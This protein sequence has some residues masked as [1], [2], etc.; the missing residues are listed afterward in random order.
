MT[1]DSTTKTAILKVLN[2]KL[3]PY[4]RPEFLSEIADEIIKALD[5]A[6]DEE[7]KKL[8]SDLEFEK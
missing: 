7:I 5:D 6:Y 1:T 3:G 2:K 8:F 4:Q